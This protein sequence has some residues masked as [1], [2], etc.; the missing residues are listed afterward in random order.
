MSKINTTFA[1][2]KVNFKQSVTSTTCLFVC[3]C[4]LV[5]SM[6]ICALSVCAHFVCVSFFCPPVSPKQGKRIIITSSE[7]ICPS[8]SL[9]QNNT[10]HT[11]LLHTSS[12]P[13]PPQR[14][15]ERPG[16]KCK[17]E[18]AVV[19]TVPTTRVS[20]SL[21]L[22]SC[23]L[24]HHATL[25]HVCFLLSFSVTILLSLSLILPSLPRSG[26]LAAA[27]CRCAGPLSQ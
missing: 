7:C 21:F 26:G 25:P 16:V 23:S 1:F 14:C 13:P 6:W 15:E 22:P 5:W 18:N 27:G 19:Q 11:R 3:V 2:S 10:Q 9:E 17:R 4:L 20:L 8:F 12:L 24:F